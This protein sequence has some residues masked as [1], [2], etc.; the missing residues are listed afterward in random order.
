[1]TSPLD[2]IKLLMRRV[3]E[4]VEALG[5]DLVRFVVVPSESGPDYISCS[6]EVRPYAVKSTDEISSE[7]L[8][9]DFFSIL[10]DMNAEVDED[11][12]VTLEG[13]DDAPDEETAEEREEREKVRE[14]RLKRIMDDL[15][16]DN[17]D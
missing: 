10:G 11:G 4:E 12:N 9:N 1:M 6:F 2:D 8:E 14:S 3:A 17:D 16:G 13:G 7:R 5:V 15:K